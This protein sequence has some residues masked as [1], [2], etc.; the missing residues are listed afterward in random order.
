MLCV[1]LHKEMPVL[2]CFV[3]R[4]NGQ[5][6]YPH[7]NSVF[8][9]NSLNLVILVTI[10]Y[11]QMRH[12]KQLFY[13]AHDFVDP[14]LGL[15]LAWDLSQGW[16]QRWLGWILWSL[17]WAGC[18]RWL[19]HVA[20]AV[21]GCWLLAGSSGRTVDLSSYIWS[22]KHGGLRCLTWHLVTPEQIFQGKQAEA[23]WPFLI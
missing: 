4:I 8:Q 20:V 23:E 7:E 3:M 18:S 22:L 2:A 11:L 16:S 19:C 1:A 6:S 10:Y 9:L 15:I 17:R 12:L 14:E 21:S 5:V 13:F